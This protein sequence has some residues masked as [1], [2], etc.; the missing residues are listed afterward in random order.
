MLMEWLLNKSFH[1]KAIHAVQSFR[2]NDM[3]LICCN[4]IFKSNLLNLEPMYRNATEPK[5]QPPS[6]MSGSVYLFACAHH[7]TAR[8]MM[9]I[10]FIILI[11]SLPDAND[12]CHRDTHD[13]PKPIWTEFCPHWHAPAAPHGAWLLHGSERCSHAG[14]FLIFH[15]DSSL[16]S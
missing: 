9:Q 4:L 8:A 1:R 6:G 14:K 3:H 5:G 13:W 15:P 11:N 2:N 16:I 12:E 10:K 7:S